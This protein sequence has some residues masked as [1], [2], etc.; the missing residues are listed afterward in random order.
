MS[1]MPLRCFSISAIQALICMSWTSISDNT[2]ETSSNMSLLKSL[3]YPSKTFDTTEFFENALRISRKITSILFLTASSFVMSVAY[4]LCFFNLSDTPFSLKI[5]S[6]C[7]SSVCS[8]VTSAICCGILLT[9]SKRSTVLINSF[10]QLS[11]LEGWPILPLINFSN[12]PFSWSALL[13]RSFWPK[14]WTP[15]NKL[16][17]FIFK[18][19]P[20]SSR[21]FIRSPNI[22]LTAYRLPCLSI[23]FNVALPP[24]PK[25][26]LTR[27]SLYSL[28]ICAVRPKTYRTTSKT[29]DFP[30]PLMPI[31]VFSSREN[32][33][34]CPSNFPP[35]NDI[36]S[37]NPC[38]LSGIFSLT[39]SL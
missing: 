16:I 14:Y 22:R 2:A 17:G 31:S 5:E 1:S 19:L 12:R 36:D 39:L 26:F 8:V 24:E 35:W 21:T 9:S 10:T 23:T 27:E 34:V 18:S 7:S 38:L 3:L 29:D 15:S 25:T 33:I 28:S 6:L 13:D 11:K 32:I 20:F 30:L 37:I 4:P